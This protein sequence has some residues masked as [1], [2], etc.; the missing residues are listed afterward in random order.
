MYLNQSKA[1]WRFHLR[2]QYKIPLCRDANCESDS[3]KRFLCTHNYRSIYYFTI[4][5]YKILKKNQHL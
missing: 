1:R 5:M 4:K 2:H 3:Q